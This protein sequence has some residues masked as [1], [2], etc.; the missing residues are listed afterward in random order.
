[1]APDANLKT[2]THLNSLAMP[3]NMKLNVKLNCL[4]MVAKLR[5]ETRLWDTKNKETI[6]MR[7]KEE[8]AD[9]RYFPDP[10]LPIIDIDQA[11]IERIKQQCL[12]CHIKNLI[13]L[14]NNKGLTPYE[15]DILVDDI[16]LAN[17]YDKASVNSSSKQIVNWILRD[18]IGYLNEHKISLAEFKVT[19]EKLAAIVEMLEKGKSITM[20]QKKFLKLLRKLAKSRAVVKEK[21]LEQIGSS[22]ELEAII[23]EIV[24]ANP[25]SCTI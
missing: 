9:Y 10:D 5:Q 25:A 14:V 24:D 22:A 4:K 18:V 13:A 23:K 20:R 21:G 1:M 8:A 17:Y 6:V 7:S 3:L 11:W 12:N 19:P 15:A 2:L 16:D